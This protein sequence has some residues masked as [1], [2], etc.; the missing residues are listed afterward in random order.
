MIK[1]IPIKPNKNPIPD[2]PAMRRALKNGLTALAKGS[3]VDFKVTTQTWKHQPDFKTE[4]KPSEVTVSTD[5]SI[6][7]YVDEGTKPHIITPKRGKRLVFLGG[8]KPKTT[9]RSISS[10]P[11]SP[12]TTKAVAKVV[13]HPGTQARAFAETIAEKWRRRQAEIM[14]RAIN[15]EVGR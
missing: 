8:S 9:P 15:A 11:G 10:G 4:E 3:E 13:K 12:G 5:D 6:Y 14:Q 1:L 7:G 2:T